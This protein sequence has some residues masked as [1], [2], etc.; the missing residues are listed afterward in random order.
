MNRFLSTIARPYL[1]RYYNILR[2]LHDLEVAVD[3]LILHPS[4]T[5]DLARVLNGQAER[6]RIFEDIVR[7]F[8]VREIIETGTFLGDSTGFFASRLPDVT[9]RS[10]ELSPRFAALARGRLSAFTNVDISCSDSRA[11]LSSLENAQPSPP[12]TISFAYL[13]AHWDADLPL[14][15]ELPLLLGKRGNAVIMIDDFEVPG[16]DGYSFD[17]Y[18]RGKELTMRNFLPL[19]ARNGLQAF[20]PAASSRSETGYRR[21]CVVLAPAGPLSDRLATLLTLRKTL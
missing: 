2:R 13:D 12:G 7:A 8:D 11:F 5:A 20:S 6:Q 18:G 14:M 1:K 3:S 15:E 17:S 21:G 4:W 9:V 19:F 16:D 10:C